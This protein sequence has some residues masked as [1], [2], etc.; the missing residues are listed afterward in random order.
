ME[1]IKGSIMIKMVIMYNKKISV[2]I[3]LFSNSSLS[4]NA[5]NIYQIFIK[6]LCCL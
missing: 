5:L 6:H 3:L 2:F 4:P 1:Q